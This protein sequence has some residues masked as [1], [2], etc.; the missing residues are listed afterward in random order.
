MRICERRDDILA[1]KINQPRDC[2]FILLAQHARERIKISSLKRLPVVPFSVLEMHRSM[3]ISGCAIQKSK[4]KNEN[5][6]P[7]SRRPYKFKRHQPS[8]G[9]DRTILSIRQVFSKKVGRHR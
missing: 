3:S 4:K 6:K 7:A 5:D 8:A 9:T 2:S 1:L